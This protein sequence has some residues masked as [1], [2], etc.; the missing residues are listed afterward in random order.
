MLK[1]RYEPKFQPFVNVNY[2]INKE[3][4]LYMKYDQKKINKDLNEYLEKN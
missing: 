1:K 2:N 4:Y 3:Y